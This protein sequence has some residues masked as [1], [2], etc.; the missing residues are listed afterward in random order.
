MS[1]LND[2]SLTQSHEP[3]DGQ[4]QETK[5]E[6]LTNEQKVD[7]YKISAISSMLSDI[8][9]IISKNF[10]QFATQDDF[11]YVQSR[12]T[13][14]L[15]EQFMQF[16]D[17]HFS[18]DFRVKKF[19][20]SNVLPRIYYPQ[21]NSKFFFCFKILN[22]VSQCVAIT[23]T[24]P[25][26][27][28]G[29]SVV[30]PDGN[31]YLIGGYMPLIKSFLKNTFTLDEHR[32]Q[33]VALQTMDEARADHA[34]MIEGDK[35]YAFGGMSSVG[36]G[37]DAVK[38]LNTCEVYSISEDKWEKLPAFVHARQQFSV[39]QFNDK[40]I[41]L[42]GGK[43]LRPSARVGKGDTEPFD[44]VKEVEIFEIEK[45]TWKTINY[46]T[47]PQR[48]AI[49]S[50]GTTQIA[51]SQILIFGGLVASEDNE[52]ESLLASQVTDNGKKLTL[53]KHSLILDVTVGSVKQGPE[54][55]TPSYFVSGG[56]KLPY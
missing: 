45:Q 40:F 46:I 5:L 30:A 31:L 8:V 39:C 37:S 35:I 21:Q 1:S 24:F 38:S 50:P 29:R 41:F 16:F 7:T 28:R 54:L 10:C 18:G 15:Q 4:D 23:N 36:P 3:N 52:D 13:E 47:E 43:K 14:A 32:S 42:F 2:T 51:G 9:N 48:L 27:E 56:Y 49:L 55:N 22:N 12:T 20:K 19:F 44:I 34:L 26:P 33:L 25:V 53:T 6:S 17:L 11:S